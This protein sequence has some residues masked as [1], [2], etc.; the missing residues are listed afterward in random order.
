MK[1]TILIGGMVVVTGGLIAALLASNALRS[2]ADA[3]FEKG[4]GG[5][6]VA[7]RIVGPWDLYCIVYNVVPDLNGRPAPG[8]HGV[9]RLP[10]FGEFRQEANYYPESGETTG[11]EPERHVRLCGDFSPAAAIEAPRPGT[12]AR[13]GL[14]MLVTR[15]STWHERL[16]RDAPALRSP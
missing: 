2:T 13:Y 6:M 9:S 5:G 4:R 14:F 7:L 3:R 1:R 15:D 8:G 16:K 10:L 12:E 11:V